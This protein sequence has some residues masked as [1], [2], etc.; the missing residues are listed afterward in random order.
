MCLETYISLFCISYAVLSK[1]S[2]AFLKSA[3]QNLEMCIMIQNLQ[4][5]GIFP[6]H[7]WVEWKS[8]RLQLSSV[9]APRLNT[10]KEWMIFGLL[11]KL[12]PAL[13]LNYAAKYFPSLLP[14]C[15]TSK[16]LF[17]FVAWDRAHFSASCKTKEKASLSFLPS[18]QFWRSCKAR[19]LANCVS[20]SDSTRHPFPYPSCKFLSYM[21]SVKGLD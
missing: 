18:L 12:C 2:R 1:V 9:W 20:A 19:D 4:E 11:C 14:P 7:S 17:F 5:K 16:P 15:S 21:V 8:L 10:K 13:T 3:H 6:L